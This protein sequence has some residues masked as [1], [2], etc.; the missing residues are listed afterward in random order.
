M[1]VGSNP[2]A[3]TNLTVS[4]QQNNTITMED[5]QKQVT[6]TYPN[7]ETASQVVNLLVRKKPVG[8]GRHSYSSY[9]REEYALWVKTILD[10]MCEDKKPRVLRYDQWKN[11]SPNTVYLRVN[12]S[13]HYLREY[14]DPDHKYEKL[15][16]KIKVER[17]RGVGVT[18]AFVETA[19]DMPLGEV[20]VPKS[21]S[22]KWQKELDAYLNDDTITKPLHISNLILTPEEVAKLKTEL[23][24]LTTIQFSV[25]HREIKVIKL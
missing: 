12:Q 22:K 24:D 9:F 20:Y 1:H 3:T 14:L 16:T 21:D 4:E 18:L 10:A 8:W 15:L 13:W 2:T 17:V 25:N 11:S 19:V 23:E 5:K 6:I 7:A